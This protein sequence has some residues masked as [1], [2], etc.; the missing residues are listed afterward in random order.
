MFM[1]GCNPYKNF[2]NSEKAELNIVISS[3]IEKMEEIKQIPQTELNNLD[4]I[5]LETK[6]VYNILV[7][8]KE[9]NLLKNFD[10]LDSLIS[11]LKFKLENSVSIANS[12]I[13]QITSGAVLSAEEKDN[14][15]EHS[16]TINL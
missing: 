10:S 7:Q 9:K 3:L 16:S 6:N 5:Q 13:F 11:N 2:T 14:D 12:N 8:A 4:K 15:L 1:L